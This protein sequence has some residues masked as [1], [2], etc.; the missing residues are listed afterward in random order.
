MW[1]VGEVARRVHLVGDREVDGLFQLCGVH[2]EIG[3]RPM[4][5]RWVRPRQV[6]R[7]GQLGRARLRGF[8]AGRAGACAHAVAAHTAAQAAIGETRRRCM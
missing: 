1:F 3:R 2:A 6:G 5:P 4:L 8:A 7:R